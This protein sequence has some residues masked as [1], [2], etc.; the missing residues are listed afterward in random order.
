MISQRYHIKNLR[1]LSFLQLYV[2]G[3][4]G[5]TSYYHLKESLGIK[6]KWK[7]LKVKCKDH[8]YSAH[9]LQAA[10]DDAEPLKVHLRMCA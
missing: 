7:G 8:W 4:F 2:F 10:F 6:Y 3:N 9:K 5:D 1:D